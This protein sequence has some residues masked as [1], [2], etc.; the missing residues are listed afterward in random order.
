MKD[1]RLLVLREAAT[2]SAIWCTPTPIP[3]NA[4]RSWPPRF[5]I[6]NAREVGRRDAS[7][8]LRGSHRQVGRFTV[9]RLI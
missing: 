3:N 1:A 5:R 4:K 2:S 7:A 9:D 6:A 8:G